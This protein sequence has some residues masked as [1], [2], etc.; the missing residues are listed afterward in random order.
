M[1]NDIYGESCYIYA[2]IPEWETELLESIANEVLYKKDISSSWLRI[3]PRETSYLVCVDDSQKQ[4]VYDFYLRSTTVDYIV[5]SKEN[6]SDVIREVADSKLNIYKLFKETYTPHTT[7]GHDGQW[8]NVHPGKD[9][10][11]TDEEI[12]DKENWIT[13]SSKEKD[14]IWNKVYKK[15]KFKP[16]VSKYPSFKVPQ[17]FITYSVSDY[18]GDSIDLTAYNDLEEKALLAFKELTLSDEYILALDWQHECYWVNTH[19]PFE[20]NQFGEWT[21]PIFPNGDYYFFVEKDFKWGYLGHPWEQS[22]TI[23]GE[24]LISTFKNHRPN[25]FQKV[26]RQG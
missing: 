13:L 14:Q 16:S 7:I 5:Y 6:M 11:F 18:V 1:L 20:K 10:A 22:I 17:P 19:I 9:K 2:I 21:V 25:M 26:L 23:F 12:D 4:H 24:E 8:L 15:F 3:F